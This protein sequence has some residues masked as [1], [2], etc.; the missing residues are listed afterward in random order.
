MLDG[1]DLPA[2]FLGGKPVQRTLPSDNYEG[3]QYGKA[4][5]GSLKL[6]EKV[7]LHQGRAAAMR[8]RE[9]SVFIMEILA[10]LNSISDM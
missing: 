10:W 3:E 5:H 9:T 6:P 1:L 4:Q 8:R 7:F 2:D